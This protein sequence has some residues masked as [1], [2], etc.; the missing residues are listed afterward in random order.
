M[1]FP[2]SHVAVGA[3]LCLDHS[4]RLTVV[5]SEDLFIL[6]RHQILESLSKFDASMTPAEWER[7]LNEEVKH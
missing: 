5:C 2:T 6:G 3:P 4:V 7:R 1:N